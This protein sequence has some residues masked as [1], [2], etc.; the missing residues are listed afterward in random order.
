[1]VTARFAAAER[2]VDERERE[3]LATRDAIAVWYDDCSDADAQWAAARLR[4]QSRR[5]LVEPTPLETWPDVPSSVVLG[6]D[7]R[8]VNMDW[9]VPAAIARTGEP[10]VLLDGGHSPFLSRPAEL[11]DLLVAEAA[12]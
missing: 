4:P 9:A 10:P 5:P 12:R 2:V 3:S 8:C 1:M 7:D 11:A 6:R